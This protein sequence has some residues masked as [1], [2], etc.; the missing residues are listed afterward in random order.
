MVTNLQKSLENFKEISLLDSTRQIV[1]NS[2]FVLLE[3]YEKLKTVFYREDFEDALDKFF[4]AA[5]RVSDI[6]GEEVSLKGVWINDPDDN[7]PF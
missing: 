6:L 1:L 4:A 5:N 3:R 2:A 7:L